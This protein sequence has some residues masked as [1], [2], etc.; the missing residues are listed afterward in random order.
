[1]EFQQF[2]FW[3]LC[4]LLG[5][6]VAGLGWFLT[7]LIAEIKLVRVEMSSLNEKLATVVTNQDWHGKELL[8]LEKRVELLETN[9]PH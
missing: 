2:A 9:K 3:L 8:R 1:M 5:I 4:G 6:L 7:N